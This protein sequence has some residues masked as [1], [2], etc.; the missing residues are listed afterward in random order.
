MRDIA[1][2]KILQDINNLYNSNIDTVDI[3]YM[4]ALSTIDAYHVVNLIT[5]KE[6]KYYVDLLIKVKNVCKRGVIL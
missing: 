2:K 6:S 5:S 4:Y 3:Y 1:I